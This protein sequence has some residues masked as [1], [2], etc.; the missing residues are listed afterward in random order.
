ME[1]VRATESGKAV[2]NDYD[3]RKLETSTWG[4]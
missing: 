1:T 2:G 4:C 3:T